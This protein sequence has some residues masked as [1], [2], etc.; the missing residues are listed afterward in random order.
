MAHRL[1]TE[2]VK[3]CLKLTEAEMTQF[4]QIFSE[5]H[6][7]IQVKVFENGNQEMVFQDDSGEEL[8]LSFEC[9]SGIY[10][11]EGS[12]RVGTAELA[13]LMRKAVSSFKGDAIV[14]RIYPAFTMVYYYERGIVVKIV[15]LTKQNSK[16]IYEYKNT[17]GKLEELF[18]KR[19]VELEIQLI[20][21]DIN[22]LLDQRNQM[23]DVEI[24]RVIDEQLHRM[25]HRLFALEA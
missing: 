24:L 7:V 2:Y 17:Q 3:A 5:H 9:K 8:V 16:I 13:N 12:Y 4:V 1:A 25:T 10:V 18:Q 22:R 15:E 19:S 14:N 6:V 11:S 21:L 23:K 20:Q